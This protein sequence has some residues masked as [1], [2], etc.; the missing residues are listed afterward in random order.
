MKLETYDSAGRVKNSIIPPDYLLGDELAYVAGL[1]SNQTPATT[2]VVLATATITGDGT[3]PVL[4]EGQAWCL[5][6]GA[7]CDSTLDIMDGG[8]AVSPVGSGR[9]RISL[10][11]NGAR[12]HHHVSYRLAPFTGTK[13]ITIVGVPS[14]N[15]A[16]NYEGNGSWLRCTRLRTVAQYAN[17]AARIHRNGAS[18]TGLSQSVQNTVALNTQSFT[19]DS[20]MVDLANNQLKCVQTGTYRLKGQ[21]AAQ[22]GSTSGAY[23]AGAQIQVNGSPVAENQI[24][25]SG[26]TQFSIPVSTSIQLNAGDLVKLTFYGDNAGAQTVGYYSET[27]ATCGRINYLEMEY[28][29]PTTTTPAIAGKLLTGGQATI[30]SNWLSG[31]YTGNTNVTPTGMSITITGDGVTPVRI[32]HHVAALAAD[33]GTGALALRLLDGAT[34]VQSVYNGAF[35]GGAGSERPGWDFFYIVPAFSGTKTFSIALNFSASTTNLYYNPVGGTAYLRAT[36]AG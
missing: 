33:S 3:N 22:T 6:N 10:Y 30:T 1:T 18:V 15:T 36:W 24:Y 27:T 2:G 14:A 19:T 17:P 31:A 25:T 35:V 8:V 26:N 16:V 4:I 28:I 13:T 29:G 11:A 9:S 5:A 23:R 12:A 32:D 34:V 21:V 20:N 7:A